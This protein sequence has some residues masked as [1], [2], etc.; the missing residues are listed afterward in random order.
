VTGHWDSVFLTPQEIYEG[1]TGGAGYRPLN[2]EQRVTLTEQEY[3]GERAELIYTLA[4]VISSGWQGDAADGAYGAAKPLADRAAENSVKLFKSQDLLGRQVGSFERARNSVV[5]VSDPPEMSVD[6]AFPFDV[7]HDKAVREHQDAAHNNIAVYREYD[8]ASYYNEINLPQEYSGDIPASGNV[9]VK[10]PGD[11]IKVGEPGPGTGE[12][13]EG[14]PGDGPYPGSGGPGPGGYR[15]GGPSGGPTGS[16]GLGSGSQTAPTDYRP[17]PSSGYPSTYPLPTYPSPGQSSPVSGSPPGEFVG[18]VPVGGYGSGGFGSRG[19]GPGGVGGRGP[20]AGGPGGGTA[21]GPLGA[22]AGAG[23]LAAEEAA[24]ARR[25][26]A[27]AA[28]GA[29]GGGVG[30]MGAPVGAGRGKD[31]EEKEHQRK[32]L[33]EPDAEGTFGSDVL[34][35]P[36]VIGDDE[37]EDD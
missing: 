9:S 17:A 10:G 4:K 19:G 12:P 5:P 11:V 18:G 27:Q 20:G 1:L 30:P 13:R 7:D 33:I 25:A 29:R 2:Q 22:G 16:G 21:R 24:I 31:D 35:A 14:G 28:A 6:E 3:E 34:T 26:A 32:V 23:A 8:G 37:Y 15:G 36:Q